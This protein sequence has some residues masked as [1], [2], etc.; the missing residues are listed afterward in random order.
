[1]KLKTYDMAKLTDQFL[2]HQRDEVVRYEDNVMRT[3]DSGRQGFLVS[4]VDGER[5]I[6]PNSLLEPIVCQHPNVAADG[7]MTLVDGTEDEHFDSSGRC[8]DCNAKVR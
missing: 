5:L 4:F 1:M 8:Y 6:V 3:G 7:V 2:G